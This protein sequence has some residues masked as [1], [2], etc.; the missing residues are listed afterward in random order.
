MSS[1]L[2]QT[3]LYIPPPRRELVP[4]PRLIDRLNEGLH[5]KLI[6]ISAPAGFGKTT[7]L[8]EWVVS[9]KRPVAWVSLDKGDNDPAR[10][11]AYIV[12]AL[13]TIVEDIGEGALS[14]LNSPQTPPLES[15]LTTLI[16]EVTEILKDVILVLDDYHIIEAQ[17]VDKALTFLLD[18]LPPQ[19]HLVIA[20]RTDPSLPLSRLR[21]S[22][23]MTEIRADDLRF[24]FDEVATFLNKIMGLNL[25]TENVAALEARTEGWIAGLQLAALSMQGHDAKRITAFINSFT[26][27]N[28]YILDY[29]ADEVL[30]QRP[31]GTKNFLL[32]TSILDRLSGSLCNAVTEQKNSQTILEALE[33]ANLF[34]VPLDDER[35]WYRYHHLFANLLRSR[36]EASQPELLPTLHHQ[37]STWYAQN[38]LMS[39]AID[40]SLAAKDFDQAAQLTEQTFFDRMS[41]GEDFA[42]MLARLK[43][44]PD[45]IIRAR[46]RLGIMYAWMLA[47]TLQLDAVEPLLQEVERMDG[48]QLP[49]DLQLQIVEIRAELAR[50]RGEFARAIELSHQVHEALPEERSIADMQTLTG[51]VFNLA[52]GYLQAGDVVKAQR[53]FAEALAISQA[54]GS[55]HLILL[56]HRGLAQ[57]HELQG[58]LHQACETYR[59]GLQL[60]DEAAQQSGQ[61]VPAIVYVDLGLGDL[62]RKWNELDE[63]DRRLAQ[64]ME[65]GRQWQIGGDTL[66]DGY[67]FQARLK[68]AQGDMTGALDMIKQAQG[69]AQAY[70]SV[71]GFGDPI[72]ACRARLMLAQAMATN[73][74]GHLGAIQH[75]VDARGLRADGPIDSLNDEV[76]YLIWAR[77]LIAQNEPDQALQLLTRLLQAAENGGRRGR[78]IEI[79]ALQALAQQALGDA[80]QALMIIE[81]ALTLAEPEGYIRLF[82]DEGL[83]M[84]KLLRKAARRG[85]TPNY[86]NRLLTALR[87]EEHG[88]ERTR[89]DQSPQP[90]ITAAPLLIEPLSEREL[91]VLRLLRTNLSG[92]EIAVELFVSVNTIKTHIKNIY[93]K[94]DAHSRYEAVER[95]KQLDIL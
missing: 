91:D 15:I 54:A 93:S 13:Q 11:L 85:I 68:E 70:Q 37:A 92:P 3:K 83:P 71:P 69:L 25:S 64:G 88:S 75:W 62:L 73:D 1:S 39:E 60:A 8:S 94:L 53:W 86:V 23:L 42:T 22:G 63:A 28:R 14:V 18:H 87:A 10:F 36:L 33:A 27:S 82:V 49:A 52:W 57:L 58:Q 65:M 26:G 81:R 67:L 76:E 34:I 84:A 55:L 66:R 5:R 47:I 38:G 21:A 31:K 12:A 40:H 46:P 29:L 9:G 80:E 4:R 17:P 20:S 6:L 51:A 74:T 16:N 59:Q 19:M 61:P 7:L 43:A 32:Q 48:D 95:A 50:H 44:L 35:C 2:L 79:W 89:D 78:V 90:P 45:D 72:A 30:Q 41:H 56:T 24:T 77:L